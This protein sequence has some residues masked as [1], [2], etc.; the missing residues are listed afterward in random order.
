M[1]KY[2]TYFYTGLDWFDANPSIRLDIVDKIIDASTAPNIR[3]E[4]QG[5]K[6]ERNINPLPYDFAPYII[7]YL[8]PLPYLIHTMC[9]QQFAN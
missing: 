2:E 1:K 9:L 8:Y 3:N 4:Q 5:N 6:K 7:L